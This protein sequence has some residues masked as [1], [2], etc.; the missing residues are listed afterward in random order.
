MAIP[1]TTATPAS[2]SGRRKALADWIANP[3]NPLTARVMVNRVW[4]H[5]FG[6]GLVRTTTDFGRV[7][8]LPTHPELLDWL[9]ADFIRNG[10][11]V[12]ALHRQILTSATWKQSS[13]AG[14]P[15]ALAQ[16]PGNELL[17]RQNLRR[18]DAEALRDSLL[19]IAGELNLEA[20]VGDSSRP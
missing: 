14:D 15:K 8:S 1:A 16:D 11:S 3:A 7:G 12:K 18:L 9:A 17:W 6:R 13:A 2:T 20:G 5:H 4:H 19:S 10:W